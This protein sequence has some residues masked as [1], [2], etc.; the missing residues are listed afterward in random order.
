MC[1]HVCGSTQVRHVCLCKC[2]R[3]HCVCMPV[4]VM[5]VRSI[6]VSLP[7]H[8]NQAAVFGRVISGLPEAS[9]L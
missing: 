5:C 1:L 6:E 4:C 7:V 3:A 2:V 9:F 8:I